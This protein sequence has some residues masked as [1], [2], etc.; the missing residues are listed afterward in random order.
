MNHYRPRHLREE[1]QEAEATSKTDSELAPSD[2]LGPEAA[3]TNESRIEF[4][5]PEE[6]E[7]D[8]AEAE[9]LDT[10]AKSDA[11]ASSTQAEAWSS[12]E[13]R[14]ADNNPEAEAPDFVSLDPNSPVSSPEEVFAALGSEL[15]ALS[16]E[17]LDGFKAFVHFE[18][19]L[20]DTPLLLLQ[21]FQDRYCA[22]YSNLN[23][24]AEEFLQ[25]QRW[26]DYLSQ[27][28]YQVGIPRHLVEINRK[29]LIDHYF[30]GQPDLLVAYRTPGKVHVLFA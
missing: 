11:F 1:P 15:G 21:D 4:L 7:P 18:H 3:T 14:A 27:L 2:L 30:G 23:E 20:D 13:V 5:R 17:Q 26:Q 10:A 16:Q 8:Q 12:D 28:A 19:R 6:E 22:T 25:E 9:N 29:A 24:W